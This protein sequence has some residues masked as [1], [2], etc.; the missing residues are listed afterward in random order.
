[1]NAAT[2]K[3]YRAGLGLSC[4]GLLLAGLTAQRSAAPGG[5]PALAGLAALPLL[6]LAARPPL[7]AVVRRAPALFGLGLL[8]TCLPF[9]QYGVRGTHRWLYLGRYSVQPVEFLK[10]ALVLV[11]AWGLGRSEQPRGPREAA[12]LGGL[13]GAALLPVLLSPDLGTALVLALVAATMLALERFTPGAR[14]LAALVVVVGGPLFARFGLRP[15]QKARVAHFLAGD[16]PLGAGYQGE[17]ALRLVASGGPLGE[18]LGSWAGL[19]AHPL[20]EASSDFIL[21]VW[22][23]ETGFLGVAALLCGLAL[24]VGLLLRVAAA[25]ST[26][27]ARRVATGVAA[28]LFWQSTLNVSMVLGLLPVV[29]VPLPLISRGGSALAAFALALGLGWAATRDEPPQRSPASP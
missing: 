16:D 19:E 15:Y 9:L 1:M 8:A 11:L 18:G 6:V 4:L 10:V 25:A 20:P 13:V 17:Q 26:P 23:H 22:G 2:A 29:G 14:A 7:Q 21:A 27:A 28:L 24:V 3:V 5:S 12:L